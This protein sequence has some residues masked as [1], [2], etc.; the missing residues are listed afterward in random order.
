MGA[1]KSYLVVFRAK[2]DDKTAGISVH[3]LPGEKEINKQV[4]ALTEEGTI[5]SN[6]N[7]R[8]QGKKAFASWLGPVVKEIEGKDLLIVPGGELG[9]V[10]FEM[11]VEPDKDDESE[12]RWLVENHRIRYAPSLTVLHVISL[13]DKTRRRP[14]RT[15]WALGDPIFDKN[16][17]RLKMDK[18]AIAKAIQTSDARKE[19]EIKIAARERGNRG[20][21]GPGKTFQR[22]QATRDE[23]QAIAKTLDAP[24]N[25]L[26]LDDKATES[27]LKKASESGELKRF[28]FIHLATHGILG[29]ADNIQASLVFGLEPTTNSSQD[30]DGFLQ[31]DEV[32]RLDLNADLVALSACQTGKG[33]L[34]RGEGVT[35]IAARSCCRD[36]AGF[37]AVCGASTT[38]RPPR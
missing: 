16:D 25:V 36:R 13:W 12:G 27:T 38:R 34:R 8:I 10:P 21:G 11:L 18:G 32:T 20:D 5:K 23:V 28:R 15:L 30:N 37:C 6:A 17:E 14:D 35:S 24:E 22:L 4:A 33:R 2:G 7:A 9:N 26:V 3:E 19:L 31:L 29:S 1:E